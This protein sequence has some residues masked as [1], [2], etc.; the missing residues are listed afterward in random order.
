MRVTL[1]KAL[2][3]TAAAAFTLTAIMFGTSAAS[4]SDDI[5]TLGVGAM[6]QPTSGRVTSLFKNRCPGVDSNHYG[7]DIANASGTR[8]R[9]AYRG[10]VTIAQ[11]LSGYGNV[12]YIRHASGFETRYAHLNR[13]AVGVGR[14]VTENQLIGYMGATGN[15]T[16]PHLH[17]EVRKNGSPV[18]LNDAYNCGQSV[19][20]YTPIN[21]NFVGIS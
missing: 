7:I 19:R 13:F 8:I 16:G 17:F 6:N 4:A 12:I 21:H 2:F 20:T 14:T 3:G 10:T 1:K 11:S 18:N 15:A 5:S 9:A